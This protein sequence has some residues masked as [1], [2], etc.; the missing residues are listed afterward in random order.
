MQ[1]KRVIQCLLEPLLEPMPE[2]LS[3]LEPLAGTP[4]PTL[5]PPFCTLFAGGFLRQGFLQEGHQMHPPGLNFASVHAVPYSA[6]P[7]GLAKGKPLPGRSV[8]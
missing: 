5:E 4:R 6:V 2:P 7:C 1:V 8:S 3:A